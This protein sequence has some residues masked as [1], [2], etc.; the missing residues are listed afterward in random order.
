MVVTNDA[1]AAGEIFT[2]VI[3]AGGLD[4]ELAKLSATLTWQNCNDLDLW[5]TNPAEE[6]VKWNHPVGADGATLDVDAQA[7]QAMNTCTLLEPVENIAYEDDG[8]ALAAGIY[9]ITVHYYAQQ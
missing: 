4:P 6:T 9:Q 7:G 3:N 1:E 5:L 2:A 8:E